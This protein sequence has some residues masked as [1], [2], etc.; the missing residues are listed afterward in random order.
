MYV[1]MCI[2]YCIR[3]WFSN[4]TVQVN[5]F[6]WVMLYA[7]SSLLYA[8]T[9]YSIMVHIFFCSIKTIV[10]LVYKS[11]SC[12]LLHNYLLCSVCI[13]QSPLNC[14]KWSTGYFN[15]WSENRNIKLALIFRFSPHIRVCALCVTL[16]T[17]CLCSLLSCA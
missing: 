11:S 1:C 9:I 10:L 6:P 4:F 16:D 15:H 12:C 7:T 2:L 13:G 3:C 8:Y 14:I 17:L 5:K